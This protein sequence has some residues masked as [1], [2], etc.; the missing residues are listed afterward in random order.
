[1]LNYILMLHLKKIN[2]LKY[3]KLYS[4]YSFNTWT[5]TKN[6][7]SVVIIYLYKL[8]KYYIQVRANIQLNY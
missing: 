1:M 8:Y 4:D 3:N 7:F 5:L 2:Y 6:F